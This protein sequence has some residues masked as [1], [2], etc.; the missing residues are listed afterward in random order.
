M[1][2]PFNAILT[3]GDAEVLLH[4][5]KVS[6]KNLG[7]R[8]AFT[9][10]EIMKLLK[11]RSTTPSDPMKRILGGKKGG[12]AR[13]SVTRIKRIPSNNGVFLDPKKESQHAK[14]DPIGKQAAID[15]VADYLMITW[16]IYTIPSDAMVNVKARITRL[17]KDQYFI[18]RTE[19][20]IQEIIKNLPGLQ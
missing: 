3:R 7:W 19:L 20:N 6:V 5:K 17:F 11:E 18:Q 8:D 1:N 12:N 10:Q 9:R 16:G 13:Y 2:N 14:N 15:A 4:R